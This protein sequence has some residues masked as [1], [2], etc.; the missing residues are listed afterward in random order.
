MAKASKQKKGSQL[1]Q[2]WQYVTD[3]KR[4]TRL[5]H[6]QMDSPAYLALSPEAK[7]LYFTLQTEYRGPAY[8]PTATVTL[9][10]A[11]IIKKTG[12]QRNKLPDRLQELR[13]FGFIEIIQEGGMYRVQN[14]YKFVAAW[15][16]VTQPQAEKIRKELK[17]EAKEKAG[18][19]Y[20]KRQRSLPYKP[21][22]E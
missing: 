15:K 10:Y 20:E 11:Q 2:F 16:D 1:P 8:C 6:D 3:S 5:F 12:I 19:A 9:P 13:R 18:K 22:D 14:F 7:L 21:P 4:W 17:A